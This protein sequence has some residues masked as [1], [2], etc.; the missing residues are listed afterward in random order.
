MLILV[1]A[2]QKRFRCSPFQ[3]GCW[4]T[5]VDMEILDLFLE[6]HLLPFVS[7]LYSLNKNLVYF[8]RQYFLCAK[9]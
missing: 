7:M 3:I 9:I 6:L 2:Q 5:N 8:L 1:G 4:Q